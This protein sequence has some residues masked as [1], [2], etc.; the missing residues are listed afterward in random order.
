MTKLGFVADVH[1]GNHK[2]HGGSLDAGINLRALRTL[3]TLI[4]AMRAAKE[5][6]CQALFVLGDLFDYAK[7]EPQLIAAVQRIL[8]TGGLEVYVLVGNH[9]HVSTAKGDHA[10]GPL[11]NVG[12]IEVIEQPQVVRV[13]AHRV[14]CVPFTPGDARERIPRIVNELT[15]GMTEPFIVATHAGIIDEST[16]PWLVKSH[17]ALSVEALRALGAQAV[18]SGDW[19]ERKRWEGNILQVGSLCPTGWDNP[20]VT[21]YGTLATW[22]GAKLRVQELRGPRF[23]TLDEGEM[24]PSCQWPLYVRRVIGDAEKLDEARN[25]AAALKETGRVE[26][27]EVVVDKTAAQRE[28][29]TAVALA[30]S[31]QTLDEALALYVEE[32]PVENV[33]R[34]SVLARCRRYLANQ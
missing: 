19:H 16:P 29:R 22:D 25:E 14:V 18:L 21:G 13:G 31:A 33:S 8:S 30:R 20:G 32:M 23:V 1:V 12:M 27:C 15:E 3:E 10:L 34:D 26:V 4:E 17:N 28:T 2:L 6:A 7:P 5:Q 9:E 24:L 11:H